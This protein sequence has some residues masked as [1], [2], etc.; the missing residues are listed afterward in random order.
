IAG[1]SFL[2][3]NQ[4]DQ[5]VS[6]GFVDIQDIDCLLHHQ[7][8][9]NNANGSSFISFENALLSRRNVYHLVK[10]GEEAFYTDPVQAVL[11]KKEAFHSG[12]EIRNQVALA[13]RKTLAYQ[14]LSKKYTTDID[15]SN[16]IVS[17]LQVVLSQNMELYFNLG[18]N[19]YSAFPDTIYGIPR[20][21][22]LLVEET[23]VK[24]D[25]VVRMESAR[26]KVILVNG[27]LQW[28]DLD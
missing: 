5:K 27:D 8:I 9:P 23:W 10:L 4:L 13:Q 18:G 20:I 17:A 24:K 11:L 14:V 2:N 15:W 12:K 16:E 1:F 6:Y 28:V 7:L 22:G 26:I 19:R 3:K 21:K 25:R